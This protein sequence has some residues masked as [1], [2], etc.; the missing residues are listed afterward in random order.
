[1]STINGVKF[2]R[3][4]FGCKDRIV[5]DG[6]TI[7]D[8]VADVIMDAVGKDAVVWDG[9]IGSGYCGMVFKRRG[10][11]V[12]SSDVRPSPWLRA[13]GLVGANGPALSMGTVEAIAKAEPKAE[14]WFARNEAGLV[15]ARNAAWLDA[16]AEAI[17][18]LDPGGKVAAALGVIWAT[19]TLLQR[20]SRFLHVKRSWHGETLCGGWHMRDKDLAAEWWR[21]MAEDYPRLVHDNG[22]ENPCQLGDAVELAPGIKAGAAYW[23]GPY[24]G[25][26]SSYSGQ[27][28]L[29]DEWPRVLLG[30]AMPPEPGGNPHRRF[31]SPEAA[32]ASFAM[33]M[34][35]S[36]HIPLWIISYSDSDTM[37]VLPEDIAVLA[38]AEG[39]SV[40]ILRF[41]F[42]RSRTKKASGPAWCN[43]C[44]IVCRDGS[45]GKPFVVPS[46]IEVVRDAKD[47]AGPD[48]GEDP[49]PEAHAL[50]CAGFFDGI[51]GNR[52]AFEAAGF[53]WVWSCEWEKWARLTYRAN[54]GEEPEGCDIRAV[55]ARDVPRHDV[56]SLS[57]PCVSFALCGMMKGFDDPRAT[58]VFDAIRIA[59]EARPE[60]IFFENAYTLPTCRGGKDFEFLLARI[61][62]AGY[63]T[64]Q[65]IL[66]A[67]HYGMPSARKRTY[68][69]CFRKGLGV[70]RF[71]FPQPADEN[72]CIG[73]VMLPGRVTKAYEVEVGEVT[74]RP[75]AIEMAEA[76]RGSPNVPRIGWL[77]HAKTPSQADRIY[78]AAGRGATITAY[79]G[80]GGTH[81]GLYLVDGKVR[82]L[83]PRE[84]ARALGFP[85]SFLLPENEDQALRLLGNSV[86]V[87]VV[88]RIAREIS[89]TLR[90]HGAAAKGGAR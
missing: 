26:F 41:P 50:T 8:V 85:D 10:L 39:R 77:G 88:A 5:P 48:E 56:M 65:T 58:V 63:R 6:R 46:T 17:E 32:I 22:R 60:A 71:D 84:C 79:T 69:C 87:P 42:P 53:R 33:L 21:F 75:D 12:V 86:A 64:F 14:G 20:G 57:S 7:A 11:S 90:A 29:V 76:R 15:G 44:L 59:A 38:E 81:S 3:R 36:R 62:E 30:A 83:H 67:R 16:L 1:M 80:R 28:D 55:N 23:D 89:M 34:E 49:S 51:G 18:S 25:Q 31:S 47:G 52:L 19:E 74:W 35:R 61:D 24:C 66:D 68:L 13:S 37:R 78:S 73:D 72:V 82:R 54:F 27:Y 45:N 9:M 4:I 70:E 2:V 40:D 43:E